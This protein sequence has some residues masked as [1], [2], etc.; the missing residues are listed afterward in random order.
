LMGFSPLFVHR[1]GMAD[2]SFREVQFNINI[3]IHLI[4]EKNDDN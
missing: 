3:A 1:N 4:K 2:H